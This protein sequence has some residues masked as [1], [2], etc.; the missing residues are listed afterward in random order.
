[1]S[2]ELDSVPKYPSN[3]AVKL[4]KHWASTPR[5]VGAIPTVA[6]LVFQQDVKT[7]RCKMFFFLNLTIVNPD[8]V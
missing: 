2:K 3:R 1:M 7:A 5:V 6:C 4:T 8:M